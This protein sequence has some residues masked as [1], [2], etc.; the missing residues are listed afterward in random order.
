MWIRAGLLSAAL[1]VAPFVGPAGS[2]TAAPD[3]ARLPIADCK[4]MVIAENNYVEIGFVPKPERLPTSGSVTVTTVFVDFPDE[5]ARMSAK[6]Y[7]DE[8]MP[9]GFGILEDLSHG[10]VNFEIQAPQGWFRMPKDTNQYSYYRGMPGENFAAFVEAAVQATDQFVDYSRTEAFVIV[11]PPSIEQGF[12]VSPAYLASNATGV[13]ADGNVLRSGTVIA[14]DA[15]SLRPKVLAHEILHT[16]GLVD[17]YDVYTNS[18]VFEDQN[19]YVGPYAIMGDLSGPAPEPFAWERWVLGWITDDQADCLGPGRHELRLQSIAVPGAGDRLG[20]IPLGQ[21]R[22]LALES[23]TRHGLDSQGFEGVLPYIVNPSL[24]TGKGPIRVPKTAEGR[25]LKPL[26]PGSTYVVEGVGLEVGTRTGNMYSVTVH[27][28]APAP[29]LPGVVAGVRIM[30]SLGTALLAW[31]E[32]ANT[33]WTSITG[34]EY[35]IGKGPWIQTSTP[36]VTLKGVKRGQR[37]T[38]QV[39]AINSVGAGPIARVTTRIT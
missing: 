9:Q 28:P 8:F 39:R 36:G 13:P 5:P 11:V 7:F 21:G 3:V 22:Y 26:Q 15:P 32:P 38:V 12:D 25:F 1:L 35:R 30:P 19:I 27:S 14:T 24:P 33:G 10:K 37:I 17:L 4:P 34:Y 23:R 2:A 20:V 16:M 18:L 31:D 29:T 6:D